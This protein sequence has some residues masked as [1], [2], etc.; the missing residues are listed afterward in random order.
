MLAAEHIENRGIRDPHVLRAMRS[1]PRH[2][3]VPPELIHA[4]YD[5]NPLDIGFGVTIS[6]PFIVAAMTELLDV[7]KHHRVLEIGTGSGY[8]AAILAELAGEVFTVEIV[9][10]LAQS[11][12]ERL[13]RLGYRN[14]HVR[15][16]DGY[17]GWPDSAPFDRI[18]LT[19]APEQIPEA[20]IAQLATG[21]KLVAPVG[22]SNQQ[23]L[24]LVQKSVNNGI[25][26]R[27]VFPV[28]F[29]PMIRGR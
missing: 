27:V 24:H 20:L 9:P 23:E 16:A 28:L 10:Q 25:Q 15:H 14:V 29:V 5:D 19:A 12:S 13:W 3:F 8:Q 7:G 22:E 2:E 11:A 18:I 21:G 6:Q 26:R 4:A 17:Q 1:V